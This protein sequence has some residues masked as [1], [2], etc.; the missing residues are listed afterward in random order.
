MHPDHSHSTL[1][2]SAGSSSGCLRRPPHF[3][4]SNLQ[5]FKS[6]NLQIFESSNLQIFESSNLRIFESSNLQIFE[7]S[8]LRIFESS[9]IQIFKSSNLRIT[10]CSG[11]AD[12]TRYVHVMSPLMSTLSAFWN[13][14]TNGNHLS[15]SGM[16]GASFCARL[17][18][19]T[20]PNIISTRRSR[21]EIEF[22][23]LELRRGG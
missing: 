17:S 15:G 19:R 5:I 23:Q 22:L 2:V 10:P 8:N 3:K 11:S 4:S 18:L 16:A 1:G 13:E 6:S 14:L 21:I 9:N 7:S 20:K 12:H